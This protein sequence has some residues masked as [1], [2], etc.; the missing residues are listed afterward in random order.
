MAKTEAKRG[1]GRGLSALF[2]DDEEDYQPLAQQKNAP[3]ANDDDEAPAAAPA[4][5]NN[6][7]GR[8]ELDI[9]QLQP[10]TF[11][12]RMTF[13]EEPLNTLAESIK[14]H[15]LLQPILV[16]AVKGEQG[17]YEIIAGERRWR[18]SQRANLHK[19]PVIISTL[20]DSQALE[21]GLVENLQREDLNPV[22]E[23]MGYSRLM[24]EFDR[25]QEEVSKVLGKSRSH[26]A[27]MVRLLTLPERVQDYLRE[28]KL[29]IGHARALVTVNNPQVL[30]DEIVSKNLNVR[31]AEALTAEKGGTLRKKLNNTRKDVDTI[32][33]ENDLSNLLGMKVAIET[34]DGKSGKLRVQ[35]KTLDQLDEL[36]HRLSK[37]PKI[38]LSD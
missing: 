30:A 34:R 9:D 35:F 20:D 18:A 38:T 32:A 8:M 23:A 4:Q 15:G 12:P 5:R 3:R 17:K 10:G 6:A 22:D 31:Q 13:E 26:I 19:V 11:Q 7:L 2:D 36:I 33:L 37:I 24:N 16:R 21:V 29:T 14:A 1:L 28:G 25:T 27:N